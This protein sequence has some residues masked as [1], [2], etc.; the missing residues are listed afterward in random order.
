MGSEITEKHKPLTSW[1]DKE[2]TNVDPAQIKLPRFTP[3][4]LLGLSFL[5]TLDDGQ[6]VRAEV[7]QKLNDFDAKNHRELKFILKLGDGKI[8]ELISYVELNDIIS[9]MIDDEKVNPDNPFLYKGITE[10]A[11]PFTS[12]HKHYKGST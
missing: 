7:A 12:K 10:H 3:D 1:L 8:D 2:P 4:E 5:Q 9:D 11:G 6:V